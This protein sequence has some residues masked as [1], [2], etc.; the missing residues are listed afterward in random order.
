MEKSFRKSS[1]SNS[2]YIICLTIIIITISLFAWLALHIK[3]GGT[4]VADE[5][6][7]EWAFALRGEYFT[8][9]MRFMTFLGSSF[10]LLPANLGFV[11]LLF[12]FK[13]D[14][15]MGIQ[16]II[17]SLIALLLMYIFKGIYQRPRPL[18]PFLKAASGFSFPS[19]HTLNGLVFFGL[20]MLFL[21]R[22]CQNNL[23]KIS[24][25]I[26]LGMI[27]LMIGFSRIYLRVHYAS[28]VL[29]GLALGT[30]WL[31]SSLII[32]DYWRRKSLP[33]A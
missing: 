14:K 30:A 19:G 22:F 12:Y 32:F 25:T 31:T 9:F 3:D 11:F 23:L 16:W 4:V 26:V 7:F 20:V 13:K 15:L 10:F 18:D 5:R 33:I 17:T 28:D 8:G 2:G 24:G 29:G 27:I 21:W 6:V 1:L